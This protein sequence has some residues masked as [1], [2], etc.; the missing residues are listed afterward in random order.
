MSNSK[1]SFSIVEILI[2]AVLVLGLGYYWL[3]FFSPDPFAEKKF[4]TMYIMA[5][6]WGGKILLPLLIAGIVF[7][8][9]RFKQG[10]VSADALAL[11]IGSLIFGILILLPL[12]N[13]FHHRSSDIQSKLRKYHPYLQ[14]NPPLPKV[15]ITAPHNDKLYIMCLGGSTTQYKDSNKRGW[16]NRVQEILRN[17]YGDDN[18]VVENL[19]MQ[20]YST[21]HT[22]INYQVNLRHRKPDVIIVMHAIND[23]LHNADFSYFSNGKFREDYGHFYGPVNRLIKRETFIGSMSSKISFFRNHQDR[24]IIEARQFPGLEPFNRNL[25]TIIDI[26][27]KDSTRIFLMTQPFLFRDDYTPEEAEAFYMINMEA[28]GED[29]KWDVESGLF[30]MRMYDDTVRKIAMDR[31]IPLIDLEPQVPKTLEYFD[32]DVHYADPAFDKVA[33]YVASELIRNNVRDMNGN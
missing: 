32:D 7:L 19:G 29:K 14:I 1:S 22:M 28:I 27:E 25:N 30:G 23:L 15:D 9:W 18:I 10:K 13:F 17:H 33:N 12:G 4:N 16:P 21:L 3:G 31:G 26:A 20:W 24:Q 8:Y 5:I 2:L 6:S 11:M